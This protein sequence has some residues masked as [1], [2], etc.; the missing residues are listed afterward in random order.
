MGFLLGIWSAY[1]TTRYIIAYLRYISIPGLAV[2]LAL[3][4]SSTISFAL[5]LTSL[6]LRNL[7]APTLHTLHFILDTLASGLI[8][9]PAVVSLVFVFVWKG[10]GE[11]E[12]R[13]QGRCG[14]L[15]VDV[16]WS[17]RKARCDGNSAR[18]VPWLFWLELG[19]LRVVLSLILVVSSSL[20]RKQQSRYLRLSPR[21]YT[22]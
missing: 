21:F 13:V 22:T 17:F 3:A 14:G 5:L 7:F 4:S 15:D 2:S 20:Q 6:A 18:A 11:S 19:V 12:V 1:S 8:I 9:V 16:V 10:V